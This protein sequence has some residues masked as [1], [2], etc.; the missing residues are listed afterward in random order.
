MPADNKNDNKQND[1]LVKLLDKV[2]EL[3]VWMGKTQ[4]N[5]DSN[6]QALLS[7]QKMLEEFVS[8]IGEIPFKNEQ[9]I[10]QLSIK[11]DDLA[12]TLDTLR[13]EFDGLDN[14]QIRTEDKV[15]DL[16]DIIADLHKFKEDWEAKQEQQEHSAN[17][18]KQIMWQVLKPTLIILTTLIL[19]WLLV[20]IGGLLTDA[21]LILQNLWH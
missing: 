4:A 21:G 18:K 16:K 1:I 12:T 20:V 11:I 14:I 10:A 19:G 15:K 3:S 9:D 2:S 5:Y 17:T 13:Q 8:N 6:N 7:L